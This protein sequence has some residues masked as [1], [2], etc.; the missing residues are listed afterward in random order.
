MFACGSGRGKVL[1]SQVPPSP[2]SVGVRVDTI[3]DDM[4]HDRFYQELV[5]RVNCG[6]THQCEYNVRLITAY[7][8]GYA[9][10][11]CERTKHG[12]RECRCGS[13][14]ATEHKPSEE[15]LQHEVRRGYDW[16]PLLL[17]TCR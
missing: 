6:T 11:V 13:I 17:S 7:D 8:S 9:D 16:D 14:P 2:P 4:D 5:H 10:L 15:V 1:T 12:S 3:K